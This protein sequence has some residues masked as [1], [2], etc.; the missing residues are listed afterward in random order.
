MKVLN[1]L[2][3]A[4]F[5]LEKLIAILLM[6][7]ILVSIVLGVVFRYFINSPLTWTDELAIY[8]LIWLTFVGGSMSVKN[9]KA[10]SLDLVFEKVNVLWQRIFLIVGYTF[11]TVFSTIVTYMAV[12]WISNPAV[13]TQISP[14]LKISMFLPYLSIPFG[15]FC[16][17][18]HAVNHLVQSF[19]FEGTKVH[20]EGGE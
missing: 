12:K 16:L 19:K 5:K 18:I 8:M 6:S 9:G 2:S 15:L 14:G 7:V 4:L 3:D 20:V 11:V 10:A 17:T 13:L 1:I